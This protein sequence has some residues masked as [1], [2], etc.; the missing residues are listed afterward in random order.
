MQT[1]E[2]VASGA[3]VVL[4]G[5]P[6]SDYPDTKE[7]RYIG[8]CRACKHPVSAL[9]PHTLFQRA[10]YFGASGGATDKMVTFTYKLHREGQAFMRA[11]TC[12]ECG[13]EVSMKA[14]A[15]KQND[16]VACDARC[17]GARGASCECEC[18]GA[19]HG[20]AWG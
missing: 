12:S 3:D 7:H 5:R 11:L 14:V 16:A 2:S 9:V 1:Y 4:A 6:R 15:G 17:M 19:N 8:K 13:G 20:A 18:G 10:T